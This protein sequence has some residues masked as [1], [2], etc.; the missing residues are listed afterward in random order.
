MRAWTA[1]LMLALLAAP[2]VRA[3]PAPDGPEETKEETGE[4]LSPEARRARAQERFHAAFGD[5]LRKVAATRETLDDVALAAEIFRTLRRRRVDADYAL[6]VCETAH[7]LGRRHPEGYRTAARA[8]ERM[9]R[10]LPDRAEDLRTEVLA[11]HEQAFARS[12]GEDRVAAGR[13]LLDVHVRYGER[14]VAR[15]EYE[16]AAALFRRALE[17]A[18]TVRTDSEHTRDSIQTRL[19]QISARAALAA[20]IRRTKEELKARPDD[21]ALRARLVRLWVVDMDNPEQAAVYIAD[22]DPL[23]HYVRVAAMTVANLPEA[24]CLKLAEWYRGLAAEAQDPAQAAMLNRAWTYFD[25]YLARHASDDDA[26]AAAEATLAKVGD[27]LEALTGRRPI[28]VPEPVVTRLTQAEFAA[29]WTKDFSPEKNVARGGS[30]VASSYYGRREPNGVF[31]GNRTG[32][33]WTLSGPRGTFEAT[34][35]PPVLGRYVLLFNRTSARGA[36]P[37]GEAAVRINDFE[38]IPVPPRFGGQNVL[39]VD[40]GTTLRIASLKATIAGRT[41]PGLAGLEIHP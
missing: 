32:H 38:P 3:A 36:D 25:A 13:R 17:V 1:I 27:A 26:R 39:V 30:A 33:A 9:I 16:D 15:G 35:D 21:E 29:R 31:A 4:D 20:E 24:A 41:Y 10:I 28:R 18:S 40:L 14:Q 19:K 22:G 12:R 8:V 2:A 5:R 7:D 37:W 34:W 11:L 6:L 23:G